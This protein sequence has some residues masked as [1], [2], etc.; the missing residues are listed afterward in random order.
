MPDFVKW[1][2][3]R[4]D[5]LK[6]VKRTCKCYTCLELQKL[7][8]AEE[9]MA[10]WEGEITGCDCEPCHYGVMSSAGDHGEESL[11]GWLEDHDGQ[12]VRITVEVLKPPT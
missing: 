12:H 1:L 3:D 8:L 2:K 7:Q 10:V 5:A 9:V 11:L 6:D 4:Q